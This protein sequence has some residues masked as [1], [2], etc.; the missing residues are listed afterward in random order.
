MMDMA[1]RWEIEEFL[2][3]EAELLDEG[4]L[5]Q[6][7]ELFTED[8]HYEMPMRVEKEDGDE[9]S[10]MQLFDETLPMLRHRVNRLRTKSAW[11]E[12]P[13]S[14]TRRFVTNIRIEPIPGSEEVRVR[15]SVLLY[16]NRGVKAGADLLS[17]VRED[18]LR[19]VNGHW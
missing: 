16:R 3:R 2:I 5:E 14:R 19:R 9:L 11:A 13:P 18:K 4:A 1:V 12:R 10:R 6:W 15:S 17:A 8:A 7:L